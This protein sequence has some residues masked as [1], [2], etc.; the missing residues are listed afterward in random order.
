MQMS[1]DMIGVF[2]PVVQEDQDCGTES[3]QGHRARRFVRLEEWRYGART[4]IPRPH[5]FDICDE[6]NP[7][8]DWE[9]VTPPRIHVW[10]KGMTYVGSTLKLAGLGSFPAPPYKETWFITRY[11][12][13]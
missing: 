10:K 2:H 11:P 13:L 4:P 1:E 8:D 9:V 7:R 6:S 5:L 12:R 3:I